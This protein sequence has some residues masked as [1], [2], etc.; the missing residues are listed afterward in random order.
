VPAASWRARQWW[1][2]PA[3]AA[4]FPELA[5]A[6][7]LTING[8]TLKYSDSPRGRLWSSTAFPP[9]DEDSARALYEGWQALNGSAATSSYPAPSQTF[10]TARSAPPA[11]ANP[12][13]APW[14]AAVLLALF[15]LE[16]ILSHA[17]RN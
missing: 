17:R 10:G 2:T 1:I 14:L 12:A 6:S 5:A 11:I 3:A 4:G 15:L 7:T 13:P 16:R 8:L 9:A